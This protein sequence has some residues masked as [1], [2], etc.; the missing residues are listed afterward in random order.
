[1]YRDEG[2]SIKLSNVSTASGRTSVKMHHSNIAL[3]S[4]APL[5]KEFS[6]VQLLLWHSQSLDTKATF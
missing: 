3:L 4:V 2:D 6:K 5:K 1:M